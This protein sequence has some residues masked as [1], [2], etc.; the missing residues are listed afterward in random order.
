MKLRKCIAMLLVIMVIAGSMVFPANATDRESITIDETEIVS[1]TANFSEDSDPSCG[2]I[3]QVSMN[4]LE[5]QASFTETIKNCSTIKSSNLNCVERFFNCNLSVASAEQILVQET[6][7]VYTR[8]TCKDKTELSF[9]ENGDLFKISTIYAETTPRIEYAVRK[10]AQSSVL[11]EKEAKKQCLDIM[12]E[13]RA[14]FNI[15]DDYPLTDVYDFDEEYVFYTFEKLLENDVYNPYQA[16]KVVFN[17]KLGKFSI[18]RK[19]EASPNALTPNIDEKDAVASVEEEIGCGISCEQIRLTYIDDKLFNSRIK[20]KVLDSNVCYLVYEIDV[21]NSNLTFY[22]DALTGNCVASDVTMADN[23]AAFG[24]KESNQSGNG[25]YVWTYDG[26][27]NPVDISTLDIFAFN[28]W[29]AVEVSEGAAAMRRLG[30]NASTTVKS[31]KSLISDVKN[32][33]KND[34]KA[35]AFYFVG[36]G[37]EDVL[38][39]KKNTYGRIRR[40]SDVTGNWHFVFL[41]ACSTAVNSGWA[42]AFHINGYS[43][44]AF[45]GWNGTILYSDRYK[46]AMA[47]WPRVDGKVAIQKAAIDAAAEVP[48]SGTTPIK[49]YGD[50]SYNGRAWN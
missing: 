33:L 13:I 47:F 12:P 41:D 44:R 32:F 10:I 29:T 23:G 18:A 22:V 45:L 48:G 31:D 25:N 14:M 34:S 26:D 49:F 1:K 16:V 39:F 28:T 46:F 36:H 15:T 3:T 6:D 8:Y 19:F 37:S 40:D 21:A 17:K 38:G 11:S 4:A 42:D 30:Y 20:K 7:Q 35:Y 5:A 43:R 2:E 27:G 50:R 24:I 9:D